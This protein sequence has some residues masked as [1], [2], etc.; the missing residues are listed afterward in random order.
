MEGKYAGRYKKGVYQNKKRLGIKVEARTG[1][2]KINANW[3]QADWDKLL[4]RFANGELLVEICKENTTPARASL[5]HRIKSNDEFRKAYEIARELHVDAHAEETQIIADNSE[6]DSPVKVARDNLRVNV[7]KW[8][9][10]KL[11]PKK[12][13][14]KVQQEISGDLTSMQPMINIITGGG[15]DGEETDT[16]KLGV[17]SKATDSV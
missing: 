5:Y 9:A 6:E 8:R 3:T 10:G 14:D 1:R 4:E 16:P 17:T 15:V 11:E 12:Y 2:K 7:R 13:G